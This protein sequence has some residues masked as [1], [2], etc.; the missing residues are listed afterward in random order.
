MGEGRS[1]WRALRPVLL[2]GAATVSWLTFSS[3]PASADTLSD[4]SSLLGG[5]TSSV[6]SVTEKLVPAVPAPPAVTP[7]APP[8]AGLLQPVVSHISGAADNL[9]ASVPAVNQLVPAGTVS[10]VST[11]IAQVADGATTAVVETAVPPVTE[12][13]PVLEPVLEPV[14]DLVTGSAPLPLQVPELPGVASEEEL[15]AVVE[16][17]PAEAAAETALTQAAAPLNATG[18]DISAEQAPAAASTGAGLLAVTAG[19]PAAAAAT[20]SL[21]FEPAATDPSPVPAQA[22]AVPGSGAGSGGSTGN[23][24]GTAAWLST[25]SFDLP[26]AG[27]DLAGEASEHVPAPVSFDPGSSPD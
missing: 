11:P 23:S 13:L 20:P 8:T 7:V 26:I 14:T 21:S 12:T 19:F 16:P 5:V 17:A 18:I 24:S 2:A 15:Q 3:A 6:S 27:S 4:T 10:A 25:Y 9:V 1:P 22:P